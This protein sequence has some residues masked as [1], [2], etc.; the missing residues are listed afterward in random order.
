MKHILIL[1][2]PNLNLVGRREPAVYGSQS[3]D[4]WLEDQ[5]PVWRELGAEVKV[6]QS[7]H[8]GDLIDALHAH[9][10]EGSGIVFNPGGY[11]H[12]SVA[13]RDA[14]AAI[15]VPV[16]EVHLTN[17]AA[18]E[19]FRQTSLISGVCGAVISGIGFP[20]YDAAVRHLISIQPEQ[21]V[22]LGVR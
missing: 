9:G 21:G 18:R 16:V 12:T 11:T 10:F 13:L 15:S 14:I 20:G 2:G 6:V 4:R 1:Q 22:D 3:L 5:L 19:S 17:I 8:E 7:N